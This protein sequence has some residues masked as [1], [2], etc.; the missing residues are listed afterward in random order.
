MPNMLL[1]FEKPIIELE[2]RIAELKEY[3]NQKGIN[4]EAEIGLLEKKALE[5]KKKFT[6]I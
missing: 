2:N 5:L 6:R 3:A 4:L 1:D